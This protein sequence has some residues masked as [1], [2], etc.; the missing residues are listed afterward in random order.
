MNTE[1]SA[2]NIFLKLELEKVPS[3]SFLGTL[4]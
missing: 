1:H 3:D 4:A 2:Q